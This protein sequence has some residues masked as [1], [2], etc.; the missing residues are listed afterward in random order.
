MSPQ[1]S[2]ESRVRA[3]LQQYPGLDPNAVIAVART[4]GLGGG[5]GD[6]GSSFGPF[7]LHQ[8]GAYPSWAP[9]NP[10]AAQ[11]W[12]WSPAG[13]N[14]ALSR[15]N[16]VASGLHGGSAIANIVKRF[17]RPANPTSEIARAASY[18]GVPVPAG[19]NLAGTNALFPGVAPSGG[20][21]AAGGAAPSNTGALAV[22]ISS[23]MNGQQ[24]VQA[25]YATTA[26]PTF[27]APQPT[28]QGVAARNYQLM[29]QALLSR[30]GGSSYGQ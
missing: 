1:P 9:Q 27:S 7:Q 14:Y 28:D 20:T 2:N 26:A 25:P 30:L 4:E 29:Q 3:A 17:E 15:I 12:S 24:P 6:Q 21:G 10:S 22:L 13:L 8:G 18:L 19:A 23:L 16:T 5:I 11:A